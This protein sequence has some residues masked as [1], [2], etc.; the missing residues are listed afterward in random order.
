MDLYQEPNPIPIASDL[1]ANGVDKVMDTYGATPS[2][3]YKLMRNGSVIIGGV[4]VW[5]SREDEK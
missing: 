4:K 2:E 3:R 5:L 1:D